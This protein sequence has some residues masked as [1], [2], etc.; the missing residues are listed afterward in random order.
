MGDGGSG[1]L[2][3]EGGRETDG[4][5]LGARLGRRKASSKRASPPPPPSKNLYFLPVFPLSALTQH[6]RS[7]RSY[8]FLSPP[9]SGT[10]TDTVQYVR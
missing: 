1:G 6:A 5:K 7:A 2:S 10:R 8:I 9:H 3:G 4:W